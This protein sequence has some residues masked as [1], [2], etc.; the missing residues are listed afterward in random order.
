MAYSRQDE[1]LPASARAVLLCGSLVRVAYGVG[2]LLAPARMVSS[3][4]APDTHDLA[5]PRLLLRAFGGH[6][7][8]TA[9]LTL[10]SLRLYG[11]L[12]RVNSR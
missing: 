4:Y 3:G 2:A 5:D 6:Q 8:V 7:L 10:A 1:R 9:S 11:V 12:S